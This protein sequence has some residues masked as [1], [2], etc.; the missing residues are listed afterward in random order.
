MNRLRFRTRAQG[1]QGGNVADLDFVNHQYSCGGVSRSIA[2]LLGGAFDATAIGVNG[3]LFSSAN[4]N[5]PIAIGALF[6]VLSA[7]YTAG[8]TLYLELSS[9]DFTGVLDGSRLWYVTDEVGIQDGVEGY[10][11]AGATESVLGVDFFDFLGVDCFSSN[12]TASGIQK[13]AVTVGL[14]TVP[15]SESQWALSVNGSTASTFTASYVNGTGIKKVQIGHDPADGPTFVSYF[16]RRA[17]L[18][19]PLPPADLPGLTA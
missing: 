11:I 8:C 12:Q 18:L 10:I 13:I 19:A 16:M 7:G 17:K 5:R 9:A 2:S 3:M 1:G 14:I 4:T 6:D 15:E